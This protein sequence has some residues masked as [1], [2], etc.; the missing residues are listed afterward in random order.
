[1]PNKYE[2]G[3]ILTPETAKEHVGEIVLVWFNNDTPVD[4]MLIGIFEGRCWCVN[5]DKSGAA[6]PWQHAALPA[7]PKPK[8]WRGDPVI[9]DSR[10]IYYAE[11]NYFPAG[12]RLPTRAELE[13]AGYPEE[14]I[15]H[16]MQRWG[17]EE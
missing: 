2:I 8:L 4:K 3:E 9:A 15:S 6:W 17:Q 5:S 1:M 12:W 7:K 16:L 14:Q 13:A 11:N 10:W